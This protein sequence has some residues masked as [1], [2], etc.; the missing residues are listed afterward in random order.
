MRSHTIFTKLIVQQ[1]SGLAL[2]RDDPRTVAGDGEAEQAA[3]GR[4]THREPALAAVVELFGKLEILV[5]LRAVEKE[6]RKRE[7]GGHQQ[8]GNAQRDEAD[9]IAAVELRSHQPDRA[10]KKPQGGLLPR[11]CSAEY[12][13]FW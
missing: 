10:G 11:G 12:G 13:L 5:V 7:Q 8:R 2:V 1:V 4:K 3:A 9:R 6:C